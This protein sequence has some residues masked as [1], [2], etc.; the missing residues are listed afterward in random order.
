VPFAEPQANPQE[1]QFAASVP[2]FTS[3]PSAADPLQ[4]VQPPSQLPITHAPLEHAGVACATLHANAHEPQCR[5]SLCRAASHPFEALPSQSP[6]PASQELNAH[7]PVAQDSL[8]W[9]RL[10]S[11]P[12]APQL[13]SVF[14]PVSQPSVATPL[15]LPHPASQEAT[16][17]DELTHAGVPFGAVHTTLHAPQFIRSFVVL[18]SQPLPRFPS[19][20]AVPGTVHVE[21][22]HTP[23]SHFGVHPDDGHT[24][25]QP[26]Q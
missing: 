19:Q 18:V 15:Q 2:V 13:V 3:H 25:P 6:Y 5:G 16:A 12:H 21:H 26:P 9:G 11:V 14:R 8:A 4:F 24:T 10:Q 23:P 20:S 7:V 1:P 22:P 17:H